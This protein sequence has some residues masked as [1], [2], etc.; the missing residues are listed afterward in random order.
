MTMLLVPDAEAYEDNQATATNKGIVCSRVRVANGGYGRTARGTGAAVGL[1]MIE[2]GKN[3]RSRSASVRGG[4][5]VCGRK[6]G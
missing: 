4:A 1:P 5:C 6:V 2:D 3:G